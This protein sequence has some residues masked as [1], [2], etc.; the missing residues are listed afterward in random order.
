[1]EAYMKLKSAANDQFKN[2]TPK[3]KAVIA[4]L[5]TAGASMLAQE[6]DYSKFLNGTCSVASGLATATLGAVQIATAVP[7]LAVNMLANFGN[8]LLQ[9]QI[10]LGSVLTLGAV[11][12]EEIKKF[13]DSDPVREAVSSEQQD[14][15]TQVRALLDTLYNAPGRASNLITGAS[16]LDK[17]RELGELVG[18]HIYKT[19]P[20]K[21]IEAMSNILDAFNRQCGTPDTKHKYFLTKDQLFDKIKADVATMPQILHWSSDVAAAGAPAGAAGGSFGGF[22]PAGAAGAT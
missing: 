7:N 3:L 22:A 4:S 19:Q 13:V 20:N 11:H 1:M 12:Y 16:Q 10:I 6:T 9:Y 17:V 2:Y 14:K 8:F 15:V 21:W 18:N 5:A